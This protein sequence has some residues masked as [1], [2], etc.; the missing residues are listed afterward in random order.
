MTGM[1]PEL[2]RVREARGETL[3]DAAHVLRLD[4]RHLK[5]L[6]DGDLA[7]LPEGPFAAGW[8]R[9]YR[10]H[11]GLSVESDRRIP[12]RRLDPDR[13]P[14]WAVRAV[15]GGLAVLALLLA[16][17]YALPKNADPIAPAVVVDAEADQHVEVRALVNLPLEVLVDGAVV[18]H[19]TLPGGETIDVSGHTRVEV[20]LAAAQSA[21]V[22][23]N[24]ETI[25]A[26]GRQ[27]LPRRLVFIDDIATGN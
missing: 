4:P 22:R 8:L 3:E 24:G 18:Y 15:A 25:E 7:A 23:Y 21:R 17:L 26:Q 10:R 27:D 9:A 2:R 5:A 6:E 16:G 20:R 1:G 19:G 12:I 11:L 14:L 13:V